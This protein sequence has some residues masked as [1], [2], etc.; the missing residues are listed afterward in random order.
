MT[1]VFSGS[2]QMEQKAA[3]LLGTC[4]GDTSE[5]PRPWARRFA[6]SFSPGLQSRAW[7]N[8]SDVQPYA[9][10]QQ[11]ARASPWPAMGRQRPAFAGN[12]RSYNRYVIHPKRYI[13]LEG[14]TTAAGRSPGRRLRELR[15]SAR[16]RRRGLT[17]RV[18]ILP[19]HGCNRRSP[20]GRGMED[21]G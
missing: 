17:G 5:F 1:A 7:R 16:L 18:Y 3:A 20:F 13:L 14:P 19:G 4:P 9:R 12:R 2:S 6:R 15:P 11:M 10:T 21:T 8:F